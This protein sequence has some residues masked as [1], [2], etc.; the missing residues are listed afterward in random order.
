[1]GK[2]TY[3]KLSIINFLK[4]ESII[5]IWGRQELGTRARELLVWGRVSELAWD[6]L[7]TISILG[8]HHWQAL[9]DDILTFP[10]DPE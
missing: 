3:I 9:R 6:P 2:H 10:K 5:K 7:G 8:Y 1:M 4:S